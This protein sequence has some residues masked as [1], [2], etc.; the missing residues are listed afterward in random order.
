MHEEYNALMR[1]QTWKL[2]PRTPHMNPI[3]TK[4][5]FRVKYKSNGS[6]DRY[7]AWLVAWGFQQNIGVDYFNTFSPV[8]KPLTLRIMF[9]LAATHGW[10]VQQID[11]N[12][13][14]LNGKLKETMF[15]QQPKGFQDKSRP[16]HVCQLDKALYG[17]KQAPKAW[18]DTLKSFLVQ[19]GFVNSSSDHCL[20]HMR[21]KGQLLLVL[22][23]L[24]IF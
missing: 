17:L 15:I 5:V 7:K 1:N 13:A 24:M 21:I 8:I 14:F 10:K 3:T 23:M 20:F 18:Y 9:S 11:I 4:W 12:N 16:S 19:Y 6:L 22:V 2:V